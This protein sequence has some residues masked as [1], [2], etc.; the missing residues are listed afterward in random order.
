MLKTLIM[1]KLYF[2]KNIIEEK[3]RIVLEQG[4]LE[5]CKP[6]VDNSFLIEE[7]TSGIN[8][9]EDCATKVI[10]HDCFKETPLE[11]FDNIILNVHG[12]YDLKLYEVDEVVA[13]I[14]G[15]CREDINLIVAWTI[16]SNLNSNML[17]KMLACKDSI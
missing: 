14:K 16:D 5:K 17:L 12:G 10:N 8:R 6:S 1:D 7:K 2:Y 4:S 11:E 13:K 3:H 9:A 15:E